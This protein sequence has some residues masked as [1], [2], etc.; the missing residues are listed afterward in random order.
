MNQRAKNPTKAIAFVIS[1]IA[2]VFTGAVISAQPQSEINSRQRA[3]KAGILLLAHGGSA[4]WNNEVL[5]LAAEVNKEVPAEVAFGMATKRTMQEGIDKLIARGAGEIVAVPLFISSYSSVITSTEFLLGL[6]KEAPADLASFAKM[7]HSGMN[8][9]NHAMMNMNAS[10]NPLTPVVSPVPLRMTSALNRHPLVA[11]I[12]L[13]RAR[14]ISQNA[15]REVVILVAHG[16]VPDDDNARWLDDMGA[17]ATL[18]KG[19]S[20]YKRFE[21]L[22]LRDDASDP[23]RAQATA[24]LRKLV[25]GAVNDGDR[26]LIVPLLLSY[27]GIEAGIKKRLEGLNYTMSP[28]GLLPDERLAEWMLLSA[29]TK[30]RN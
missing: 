5:K 18:M 23:V 16:P 24:E 7:D 12:L 9:G 3:G 30:E 8:H 15:A 14:S 10:L 2:A 17:L 26:V 6:R 29:R 4:N 1:V 20:G 28:Q 21:Y 25:E 22:T 27:G 19:K 11:E 13:D